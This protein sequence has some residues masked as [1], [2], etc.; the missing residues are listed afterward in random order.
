[1]VEEDSEQECVCT[2]VH[3][4]LCSS[5]EKSPSLNKLNNLRQIS[6]SSDFSE[7]FFS[8]ILLKSN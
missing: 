8:I 4:G 1:M 3:A 7:L 5:D 6:L 2:R